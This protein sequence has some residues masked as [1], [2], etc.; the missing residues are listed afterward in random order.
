[1][2]GESSRFGFQHSP[3]HIYTCAASLNTRNPD[4]FQHRLRGGSRPGLSQI[5]P[6]RASDDE[7]SDVVP[8]TI[9]IVPTKDVHIRDF[10]NEGIPKGNNLNFGVQGGAGV[11]A[12]FHFDLTNV[13]TGATI[14]AASLLTH[15]FSANELSTNLGWVCRL[16]QTGWS[17]TYKT[18][19][20]TGPYGTTSWLYYDFNNTILWAAAGG[21]FT[22]TDRVSFTHGPYP[23]GTLTISGLA[24]LATDAMV[25]CS[26]Q[27]HIIL[28]NQVET[29]AT[30][31]W[32]C[33]SREWGLSFPTSGPRLSVTYE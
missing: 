2:G 8:G 33:N 28:M 24:T 27:L 26:K 9:E 10:D 3:D 22:T 11:H 30:N 5:L 20:P 21:D 31:Y 15:G 18:G 6:P 12:L 4:V 16:T 29:G 17:E 1:L 14:T 13:P 25:N 32:F 7:P 23:S 19:Y